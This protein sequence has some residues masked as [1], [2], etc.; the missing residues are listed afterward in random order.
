MGGGS[1]Q[2]KNYITKQGFFSIKDYDKGYGGTYWFIIEPLH[3]CKDERFFYVK[4]IPG[5][6]DIYEV[7][8]EGYII[9]RKE[10]LTKHL[11]ELREELEEI[12]IY[13]YFI[14]DTGHVFHEE[15][16]PIIKNDMGT[17]GGFDDD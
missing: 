9:T 1:T 3:G 14:D 4:P 17:N 11:A 2:R 6:K 7:S 10:Q 13:Y 16:G 12:I 8:G 15:A 5:K